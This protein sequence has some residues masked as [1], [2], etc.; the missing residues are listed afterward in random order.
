MRRANVLIVDDDPISV[1]LIVETLIDENYHLET[2]TRGLSAWKILET[3]PSRFDAIILDRK[4]PDLDGLELLTRIKADPSLSPI[5]VIMVT[6]AGKREAVIAGL[7]AGAYYYLVK[8][9]DVSLLRPIVRSA[10]TDYLRYQQLRDQQRKSA[11][12]CGLMRE[13]YFRFQT[14]DEADNLAVFLS[15][16][17]P[18]PESVVTGLAELL[19]NAI[20]H[21]NLGITYREKSGL[22]QQDRWAGEVERRLSLPINRDKFVEVFFESTELEIAIRV[23]DQGTGFRWEPFLE[24]DPDRAFDSHGRGIAMARILSF[25]S[26][27][28]LGCGN[29]VRVIVPRAQEAS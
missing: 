20:E 10:V 2:A 5:P 29:E 23:K 1:E 9:F 28:Y 4:M 11:H 24:I 14:L 8:P 12:V 26:L 18:M 17:C 15:N 25:H 27:E 6:S 21:G 22:I 7:E 16:A 19:I 3:G 13:G